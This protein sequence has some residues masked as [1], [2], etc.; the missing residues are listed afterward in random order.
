MNRFESFDIRGDGQLRLVAETLKVCPLCGAVNALT[1]E[2]CFIC[3]WAGRFD[4]NPDHIEAGLEELLLSCPELAE[5]MIE[6]PTTR[7]SLW[8]RI[9]EWMRRLAFTVI[10]AHRPRLN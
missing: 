2:E 10:T 9:G 8:H 3:S 4:H 7:P 5:A 1:N 6:S